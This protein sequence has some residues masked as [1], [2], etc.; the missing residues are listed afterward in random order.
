MN[1]FRLLWLGAGLFF[2]L[3]FLSLSLVGSS[4]ITA[5]GRK[6]ASVYTF[7]DVPVLNYH[8]VD[9]YDHPLSVSPEQFDRQMAYLAQQGYHTISPDQLMAH[10]NYGRRL[11]DKPILITFDDGYLD[12]YVYAYPIMKK[13]GFTG[14][15]FIITN[16]VGHDS[17]YLNWPQIREMKNNGFLFGSHT[18]SHAALTK[19]SD[20]QLWRELI[21][22]RQQIKKHLGQYPKYFAYPTGA[23][24]R[25]VE[26][27]TKQ[28]GYAAA[29]TIRYGQAGVNSDPYALER[30]PVFRCP[31]TQPVFEAR[32]KKAPLLERLG[33]VK[34]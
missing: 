9:N 30:I 22:S 13:Y 24:N 34:Q 31:A 20:E 1:R 32:L 8:K 17:R 25:K 2:C 15:I 23:Y 12:N 14:I 5:N 10:L 3:F 19:V 29:F 18:L 7:G 6:K 11:P 28:A 27:M 16:L 33:L 21:E 26:K 4:A